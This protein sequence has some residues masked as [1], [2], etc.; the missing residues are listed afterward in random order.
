MRA[1]WTW[2]G[3]MVRGRVGCIVVARPGLVGGDGIVLPIVCFDEEGCSVC[4]VRSE[5]PK[6][7]I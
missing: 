6:N 2:V 5:V 1:D 3:T 7:Y 4:R